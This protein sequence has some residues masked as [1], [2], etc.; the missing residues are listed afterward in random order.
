[1]ASRIQGITVEIG[2]DTTKL[3]KALES[4][5]KS[6]K[7]TQS[8]LKDVNKLLK[9]DPSNTELVVQKQK[10]LK[11]AIEATKE[12]LATLKTAAQQANEQLANGEITQQQYDAL[13]REIVETE[14]N[15]RSLQDQAAT[16]N[17]T[18]A[19]I[20]EAGEKLQNIG[21]SV[22]NVGKKFL[23]VTAAVTGLGTAAV[24]TAADFDSEMSKVS[25]I[26]GA[27]GDDF[28]QLRAKA[29]EMGAKT[30]FSASEAASAME[31]MAMAGWKTSDMLNGIEGV[32]NLA[33]ASGEDLA[34]TS[35]IVTDAL[36]AFGLSAADSGHFADILAAASSNANTNVSMMGETFK[37]CAP[38]AGA[39]GFSAEDTAEAI[40][41]MANSGIKASQAGTSLRTIMNNLSGEVTFAGKNIGEVTIATS[42]ADGSMRS[43]NDILADCRVAFSGLTESEK[44]SNAEALVGKNAMSGFLALMNSS[45]TDINKLRGAIEN[46]DGASESMAETMQDNLN[47]QLTILKSQLEELAISFGDI[48]MPTIRKIVWNAVGVYSD[49][50]ISGTSKEKRTGFR[51]LMRHCKDGKIDRIVCKSISRFARNTAD[52]MSA[53]DVL[54]DC[55]VT[56]LFEKENLDTADPTSDFILTTLAAIAQE[57]SR[58][59]SSNIRLGQKMRFPKGDVPNKIMY[60]YRYNGKM[61]TSESGYEY[62]DIEIVEEEARVV[63][64]IFHEVVEGKAYTEIARGLNMDKIPAPVTDA[65]R[66][67]K[68]KSK[69]GQLNS[70]L[71][72]GWTGGN[73][74]R[75]VRAERYM[76]AVLIQKKF[77]S[78]YLTH[79]VRDN[80]GEV[81]QYFVRNHHPAIVDEDLFEKAQEVVKVNSDLYNRTRSGKK[82]RAFS[83]RLIC[84]ECG[85]FFHVTN[86][87]GNYP[88]WRCPTS[89]RTTGKR[90]CHAEKVYEEQVVRAF[91]KAVLERFRLTLK[92][93]H[94]NVAVADIMSG[95]FK[96]Q[97]DNFTPEA[98]SFVSQ[99][100]A[101]LESIQKLD[102]MERDRA[103][104]KKQIAAAH[105][106]VESTSKKIRLLKS[107]VDVMQTRLELLGDEMIDPASIEEKKKLIEKLE[108][109]IQK[110]TDTEQKLTEQL[111]YM[112][113]YWEELEGDYERREK[114]IEWMK[115]LPAGRDGTVAFLNEVTEEH[116][117]AFLLS[118]TIHSPLKFTVHWFDDTK[119][120][121]EMDSNIEDYRN[122]ASYYDGHT[123]RDGSQRKRHVR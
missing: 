31:Y 103:F 123:M 15:L 95:R 51:R 114:A 56:I 2:G 7:G 1:M 47:G 92:P 23:P 12:K 106:S 67:R 77:T 42:N 43:L 102:F 75:I 118:I 99:M 26:S 6:I 121:V 32:M 111:D 69:K 22:E 38:I 83:Q 25:A 33:A 57:E 119:T 8:G 108:C 79:E 53:L 20:D 73:I 49:Y 35:D 39:L 82:P 94:D 13:Q 36:T 116:C 110:D 3:S 48:L 9:L 19:K 11:D 4:V 91:R 65:V 76:G 72:D 62:K 112:E 50:G 64:R 34:T 74:T 120:E 68:K 59:I 89:S 5:N 29:R 44:A 84:G 81:P 101:R 117:K 54:H 88:I 45:E 90:I 85:R 63:R 96:E 27:T 97:Y 87:N 58:S 100:L 60:G 61:V 55:G 40:G 41:L 115:N 78:D 14:Q 98:D 30:K 10:M 70:D 113:D 105:T 93:I 122:T 104:Y 71:L 109:D 86:G 66:V 28:D 16:T 46:C 52:F 21:S 17:A 37:Y 24:K 18:L 107:Q 80:K